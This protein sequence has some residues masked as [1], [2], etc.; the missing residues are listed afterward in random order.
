MSH[1]RLKLLF[2]LLA[3]ETALSAGLGVSPSDSDTRSAVFAKS[4]GEFFYKVVD[5]QISFQSDV[6]GQTIALVLHQNGQDQSAKR[7]TD[8]EAK[9]L[10]DAVTTGDSRNKPP[11]PVA[12]PRRADSSINC[13]A[14]RLITSNNGVVDWRIVLAAGGKV[15]SVGLRKMP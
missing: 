11:S 13:S 10:E 8:P 2:C 6:Q 3:T 4:E 12:R 7:I 15:A 9:Q 5:A 1:F 14:S